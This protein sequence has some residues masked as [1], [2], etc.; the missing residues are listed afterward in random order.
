MK[1]KAVELEKIVKEMQ[2]QINHIVEQSRFLDKQMHS[3]ME[4][5][6]QIRKLYWKKVENYLNIGPYEQLMMDEDYNVILSFIEKD[7]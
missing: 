4:K 6:E 5:T 3:L 7:M 1:L 2:E